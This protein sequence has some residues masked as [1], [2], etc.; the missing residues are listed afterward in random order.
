MELKFEFKVSVW[1]VIK[2]P[3]E[4]EGIISDAI[5]NGR[6]NDTDDLFELINELHLDPDLVEYGYREGSETPIMPIQNSGEATIE[7]IKGDDL[8]EEVVWDNSITSEKV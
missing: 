1:E 3:P 5:K 4:Y 2:V 8:S 6:I 7:I